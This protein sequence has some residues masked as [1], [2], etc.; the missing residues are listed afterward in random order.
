M[1]DPCEPHLAL[2]KCILCYIQGGHLTTVCSYT[3]LVT[4]SFWTKTKCIPLC[5]PGSSFIHKA[6]NSGLNS[7]T[8]VYYIVYYYKNLLQVQKGLSSGKDTI[9]PQADDR[10]FRTPRRSLHQSTPFLLSSTAIYRK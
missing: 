9:L 6:T 2:A 10:G 4:P 1:H 3:A 8:S 5:V 7:I